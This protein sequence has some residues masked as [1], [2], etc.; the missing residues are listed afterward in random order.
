MRG[1]DEVPEVNVADEEEEVKIEVASETVLRLSLSRRDRLLQRDKRR[2]DDVGASVLAMMWRSRGVIEEPQ[3][4]RAIC[5]A[6]DEGIGAG[7]VQKRSRVYCSRS[8]STKA[9]SPQSMV[10]HNAR[11]LLSE[12]SRRPTFTTSVTS[13]GRTRIS[14]Y[15]QLIEVA[16][17]DGGRRHR[18]RHT[19]NVHHR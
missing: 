4:Y 9:G 13:R 7:E 18:F 11:D 1:L 19:G 15:L 10:T 3:C 16:L 8:R 17:H 2:G 14:V 5:L 12:A 6:N